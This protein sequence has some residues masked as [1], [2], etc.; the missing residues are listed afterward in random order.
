[1]NR[2]GVLSDTHGNVQ[3]IRKALEVFKSEK[4]DC[5][6][7]AGDLENPEDVKLFGDFKSYIARGNCDNLMQLKEMASSEKEILVEDYHELEFSGQRILLL[8]SDQSSFFYSSA[9]SGNYDI[10]FRG[11]THTFED[12]MIQDTRILNPGAL[13]RTPLPSIGIL[14]LSGLL[15]RR[16]VL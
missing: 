9:M 13:W 10:I 5:I 4:V 2:I 1:M 6:F 7:H 15:W 14:D 8:H 3:G 12:S 11:H 16:V